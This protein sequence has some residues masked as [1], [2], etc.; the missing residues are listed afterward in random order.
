MGSV[1]PHM[2]LTLETQEDIHV[3][4]LVASRDLNVQRFPQFGIILRASKL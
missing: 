2:S 3:I 1:H 4:N